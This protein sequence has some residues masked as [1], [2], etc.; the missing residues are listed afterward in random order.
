M[1]LR[2]I[3]NSYT[4]GINPDISATLKTNAGYTNVGGKQVPSYTSTSI[5]IQ[6]QAVESEML[7]HL[8]AMNQQGE[9]NYVYLNGL[10]TA[11]R[12]T[13][14]K[15]EDLLVFKPHGE[16][17]AVTWKITKVVESWPDWTKVLV[18]RTSL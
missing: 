17:N 8:N 18:Q 12:R 2:A 9:F 6:S 1:N 15:G 11:Q 16:S 4:Q 5:M 13:L 3:A 10:A 7:A 14:N